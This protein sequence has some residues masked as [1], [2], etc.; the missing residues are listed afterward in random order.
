MLMDRSGFLTG[1]GVLGLLAG[2]GGLTSVA[3]ALANESSQEFWDYDVDVLVAGAGLGG[4]SAA[5]AAA[6]EGLKTLMAEVNFRNGGGA[7]LS[8][9]WLHT[10]LVS[11]WDEYKTRCGEIDDPTLA[12]TYVETANNEYFPWLEDLGVVMTYGVENIIGS[13]SQWQFG[14]ESWDEIF[15]NNGVFFDSLQAAYDGFGGE[16]LYKTRVV[17]LYTDDNGAVVGAQAAVW[18]NSPNEEDQPAINIKAKKVILATGNFEGNKGLMHALV[19]PNAIH[20]NPAAP[21]QNGD[22]LLMAVAAGAGLSQYL[23]R[24]NGNTV[25]WVPGPTYTEN[26]EE[27]L[28]YATSSFDVWAEK[29]STTLNGARFLAPFVGDYRHYLKPIY[30]NFDGKRFVDEVVNQGGSNLHMHEQPKGYAWAVA[31]KKIKEADE[32]ADAI[33]QGMAEMGAPVLQANTLEELATLLEGRGVRRGAFLKTVAEYNAAVT[34]GTADLLDV[35]RTNRG[36]GCWMPLDEPPFYAAPITGTCYL[37]FGG[38]LMDEHARA[39]QSIGHPVKNLYVPAPCGGGVFS[40]R[41]MG[42]NAVAGT[43]GYIAGKHAAQALKSE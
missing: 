19:G 3:P 4:L 38:V 34:D 7:I 30:I 14:N 31:D 43:F 12:K 23:D 25:A 41:Y 15:L 8:G 39:L 9:G 40:D 17:K 36:E 35:P 33:L 16:T 26:V 29:M 42:G 22:G 5:T 21:F 10:N 37:N 2:A 11:T 6:E 32:T 28:E 18:E 1:A 20:I 24:F 13:N 27:Y